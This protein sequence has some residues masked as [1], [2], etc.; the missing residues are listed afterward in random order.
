MSL[1]ALHHPPI[2]MLLYLSIESPPPSKMTYASIINHSDCYS[3]PNEV[4]NAALTRNS[5]LNETSV[6]ISSA[7]D[8]CLMDH[9]TNDGFVRIRN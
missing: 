5:S 2:I 1:H 4:D 3:T 6:G 8:L 9:G 7:L